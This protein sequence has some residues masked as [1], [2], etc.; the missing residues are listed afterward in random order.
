[1][2]TLGARVDDSG[3]LSYDLKNF[4]IIGNPAIRRKHV[5]IP[6]QFLQAVFIGR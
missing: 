5:P 2:L 6:L 3:D 4:R 1:M